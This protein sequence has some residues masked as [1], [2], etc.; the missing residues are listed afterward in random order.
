MSALINLV[1][2]HR[3]M[4]HE[5]QLEYAQRFGFKSATACSLWESGK[6]KIPNEVLEAALEYI[7]TYSICPACHGKG[8]IEVS[9]E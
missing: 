3:S 4:L 6:R 7:P 9:H 2:S 1:N 5:T 8:M